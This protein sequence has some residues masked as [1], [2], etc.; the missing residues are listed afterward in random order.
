MRNRDAVPSS[1]PGRTVAVPFALWCGMPSLARLIIQ[2]LT[3]RGFAHDPQAATLLVIEA[4]IGFALLT[5]ETHDLAP[6]PVI[7]ATDSAC[8]DYWEDLAAYAPAIL[9]AG[10]DLEPRI[11]AALEP[12]ARGARYRLTPQ[13]QSPLTAGERAVLRAGPCK[14]GM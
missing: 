10:P 11:A 1:S 2:H 5:L 3:S 13:Q 4:P 14:L 9:L 8:P 7:V 12:A 6:R